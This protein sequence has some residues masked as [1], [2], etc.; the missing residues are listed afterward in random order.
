MVGFKLRR[1][2]TVQAR[3]VNVKTLALDWSQLLTNTPS[4]SVGV[5]AFSIPHGQ[6]AR[7]IVSVRHVEL[8]ADSLSV[9]ELETR[10]D[11]K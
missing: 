11:L 1:D 5:Q 10:K 8:R 2:Q 9:R 4:V 3:N 7:W 6:R